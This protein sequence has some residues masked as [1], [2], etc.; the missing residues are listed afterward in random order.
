MRMHLNPDVVQEETQEQSPR[1]IDM[2]SIC[3]AVLRV[4]AH[5]EESDY[6]G[7][8]TRQDDVRQHDDLPDP[9]SRV[10]NSQG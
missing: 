5:L 4:V 10:N 3:R 8:N 6:T 1:R 9:A 7:E 2:V